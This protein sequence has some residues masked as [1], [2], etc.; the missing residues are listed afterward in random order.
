MVSHRVLSV[1]GAKGGV[2]KTTTSLNLG[3]ALAVRGHAVVTVELDLAMANL[4]DFLDVDATTTLH[5][6]LAGQAGVEPA[7]YHL[8]SG[9]DVVPS[10]TAIDGYA[11]TNLDRLPAVLDRLRQRYDLVLLDT[12]AG[13]SEETIRP[14]QLSEAVIVVSTPR[15]SSVRNTR[16]TIRVARRTDAAVAGLVLTR[17][18]TGESPG[19]DRIADF[20]DQDLLG[21]VP[22]DQAVPHSQD[23]G[24]SVLQAFP[25]SGAAIAYRKIAR[26]LL[27][28]GNASATDAEK[29]RAKPQDQSA[30]R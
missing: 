15:M 26:N 1:G 13:L 30:S 6:V 18:G 2:G 11:E 25:H 5:D 16:N 22:E 29:E 8:D 28:A 10:G 21:H 14:F 7:T 12:P 24:Q 4:V 19:A 27:D 3:T 20:L 23:K 9:L 17:S